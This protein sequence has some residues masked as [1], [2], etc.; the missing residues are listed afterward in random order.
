[1]KLEDD[2]QILE[3]RPQDV[4]LPGARNSPDEPASTVLLRISEFIDELLVSF[5]GLKPYYNLNSEEGLVGQLVVGLAPHISAGCIGRIIGFSQI[6]GCLA[7]PLWHAALRRD[8]DGDECCVILLMDAFLNFSRKFLPD[9]RGGRTMDAPLVLTSKLIPSE[10]DD[11]VLGLDVAWSYPLELYEAAL[12]YKHPKEVR[13]EQL[14]DRLNKES[15]YEG[16]GFTH[17]TANFNTGIR[18]SAYKLLPSMEEKLKGQMDL[19]DRI[20]AVDRVDVATLVIEKHFIKDIKGNLRRFSMQEFRCVKCNEKYRR[21]PLE[22]KC[23][24]CGGKIIF[25]I[26]EGSVTKYLEPSIS[27]AEKYNV[28]PYLKQTLEL[29]K[30]RIE[31]FFGKDKEKQE[32]LGK[33]FG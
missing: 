5:Y 20:R 11:M 18:C 3:I 33:W 17:S 1:M 2:N 22:G 26:S 9:K 14:R 24:K 31:S 6:Q 29:T 32:G 10:V 15:Q 30:R 12:S 16:M 4:I 7:H 8:C 21:P 27:I 23:T 13:V 28:Y 19:A 25:T